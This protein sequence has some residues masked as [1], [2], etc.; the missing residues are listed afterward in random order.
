MQTDRSSVGE[1]VVTL[2]AQVLE[3]VSSLPDD[4]TMDDIRYHLYL[5]RRMEEGLDA[6][7]AGEGLTTDQVRE[8]VKQWRKLFGS[9]PQ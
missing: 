2:K 4:C 8:R 5:R 7:E 6:I 3:V 9:T 1:I